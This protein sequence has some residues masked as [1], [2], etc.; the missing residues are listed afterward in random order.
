VAFHLI[1]SLSAW[2]GAEIGDST[3]SRQTFPASKRYFGEKAGSSGM[4]RQ[5][6]NVVECRQK[7]KTPSDYEGV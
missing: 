1:V 7:E 5:Q 4:E 3:A 2:A 6:W